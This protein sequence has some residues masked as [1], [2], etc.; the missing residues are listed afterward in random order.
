ME[1]AG[2]GRWSIK[3]IH[4]IITIK[5]RMKWSL[6]LIT[7]R[8]RQACEYEQTAYKVAIAAIDTIGLHCQVGSLYL[9]QCLH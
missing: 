6:K 4:Y 3:T 8:P 1:T 2:L 9:I 5:K 7:L